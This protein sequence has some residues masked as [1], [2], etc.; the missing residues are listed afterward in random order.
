VIS[1][2]SHPTSEYRKDCA[3]CQKDD[4]W[5]NAYF[6]GVASLNDQFAR[7]A[8]E[9]ID[10]ELT[11][12]YEEEQRRPKILVLA[13]SLN[14]VHEDGL[15]ATFWSEVLEASKATSLAFLRDEPDLYEVP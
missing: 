9:R 6:Y 14:E 4:A 1:L 13:S 10:C 3:G 7:A 11:R 12:Q 2:H 8:S 5:A 15:S